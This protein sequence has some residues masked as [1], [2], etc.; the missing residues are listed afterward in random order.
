MRRISL[1][2]I[3]RRRYSLT[4]TLTLVFGMISLLAIASMLS[5]V[6]L[7]D[8][9]EGDARAI[10]LAGSL[11]MQAWRALATADAPASRQRYLAGIEESHARLGETRLVQD[12]DG[13]IARRLAT[14]RRQWQQELA[15]RLTAG[16]RGE[17][18]TA[19]LDAHVDALDA[20][21]GRL[22][23]AAEQRLRWLKWL[24]LTLL[25][26][27]LPLLAYGGYRLLRHVLMPLRDLLGVIERLR[28]GDF[29]AHS[30]Y[31]RQ[32]EIGLLATT[33]DDMAAH[34]E[35]AIAERARQRQARRLAL[36]EERA[37]MARELHDSLAQA[38]SYQNI[39]ALRLQRRLAASDGDPHS[40]AI[41]EELRGG[42][43]HAYRQ[44][45][46]LLTTF[47]T[48]LTEH[49]LRAAVE[50]A[51]ESFTQRGGIWIH[52][53]V[54]LADDVLGP[55][56]E[57]HVVQILREALA[58]VV[59][60]ARA[61]RAAIHLTGDADGVTLR[62]DDDGSGL[63]DDLTRPEHYGIIIM[64]ERAQGLGGRLHFAASD[65]GGARLELHFTPHGEPHDAT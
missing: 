59:Q 21:V 4:L 8:T 3:K 31:R 39:Q 22:E 9:A 16:E 28:Q 54:T 33:V 27:T 11:R 55:D 43:E 52:Q 32:D 60:H 34:L 14:I 61:S 13:D 50:D 64:K 58:N 25:T 26:L 20:L 5:T 7:A 10:N 38:L 41:V 24:Q 30:G 63:P 57:L 36:M 12:G 42:I 18:P 1:V 40:G 2:I 45:R 17:L 51:A 48:R 37:V 53:E 44:L 6:Y 65:W 46:E 62:V 56:E 23:A 35:A 15:P 49:G 29:A 19:R 47:R